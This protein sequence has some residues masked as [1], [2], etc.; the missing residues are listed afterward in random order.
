[1][2]KLKETIKNQIDVIK[3]QILNYTRKFSTN[4]SAKST[5]NRSKES[6]SLCANVKNNSTGLDLAVSISTAAFV[7]KLKDTKLFHKEIGSFVIT[8]ENDCDFFLCRINLLFTG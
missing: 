2:A 3:F 6:K 1:M 8:L 4:I 7:E 5:T